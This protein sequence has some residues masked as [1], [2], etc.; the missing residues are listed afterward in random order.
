LSQIVRLQRERTVK[1]ATTTETVCL[2]TSQPPK[3]ADAS[4]LLDYNRTY[5]EIENRLHWVR[6]VTFG[7]DHSQVRSG[8]APQVK[9]ALTNLTV[10]L[11]RRKGFSNIA[12]AVRTHAARPHVALSLVLSAHLFYEKTLPDATGVVDNR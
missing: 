1:G 6:D 8:K 5:W 11:L 10:I 2:V 12:A 7:E 3:K 9:A 4:R